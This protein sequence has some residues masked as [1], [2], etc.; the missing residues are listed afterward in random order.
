RPHAL[1]GRPLRHV[2]LT[3]R[4]VA[5]PREGGVGHFARHHHAARGPVLHDGEDPAGP[6]GPGGGVLHGQAAAASGLL[7]VLDDDSSPRA[8]HTVRF[9]PH[10][11]YDSLTLAASLPRRRHPPPQADRGYEQAPHSHAPTLGSAPLR[12]ACPR[13][14][15]TPAGAVPPTPT[16]P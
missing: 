13:R 14:A 7:P 8:S 16:S 6:R 2:A 9:L 11:P 3:R 15:S 12:A 4:V 10:N 5:K 1:P